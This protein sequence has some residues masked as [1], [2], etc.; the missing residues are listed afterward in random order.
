MS[1]GPVKLGKAQ[2]VADRNAEPAPRQIGD[3]R[4]LARRIDRRFAPAFAARQ[5]NVEQM[6]LVIARQ[7]R[8]IGRKDKS[9]IGDLATAG[10]ERQRT[11]MQDNAQFAGEFGKRRDRRVACLR[12]DRRLQRRPVALHDIGHFRRL[13]IMRAGRRRFAHQRVDAGDIAGN[14]G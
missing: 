8:P 4:R 12:T 5:I 7:F 1:I 13:H 11:D 3:H 10:I 14:V 9:P 2:I 6:D